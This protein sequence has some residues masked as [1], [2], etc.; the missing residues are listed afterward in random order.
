MTSTTNARTAVPVAFAA[1]VGL[2]LA[3]GSSAY[4]DVTARSKRSYPVSATAA[5]PPASALAVIRSVSVGDGPWGVAVDQDDDTVY[6]SNQGEN[7]ISVIDGRSGSL[8]GTVG[9]GQAP[10]GVSVDQDDD[11]V[12]VANSG[13]GNISVVDGRSL[14]L[15]DDTVAVGANPLGIDVDQ[16]DDTIYVS[17]NGSTTVSIIDA[18]SGTR[19]T[20]SLGDQ[21][22]GVV[23]DQ[24]DD[25]L[26][27]TDFNDDRVSI[28]AG[29][30]KLVARTVGVGTSPLGIAVDQDDDTVYVTNY[31]SG[32]VSVLDG[33]SSQLTDDTMDVGTGPKGIAVDQSD[34]TVYVANWGSDNLSV[35]DGSGPS[36]TDDT[37]AVG[38]DPTGVA[39]DDDSDLVYV[40]NEGS[41]SVSVIARV[42]PTLSVSSGSP[43]DTI[44]VLLSAS[45]AY[46]FD[47]STVQSIYFDDTVAPGL[48]RNPGENSW[49]VRVPSGSGSGTIRVE[50]NGGR[51][52]SAGTFTIAQPA[53]TPLLGSPQS[54]SSG[55]NVDVTN[56]DPQWGWAVSSSVGSATAGSPTGSTLP[57]SVTGLAAGQ[58]A[59]L[60]VVTSRT[61][62]FNGTGS[63]GGSAAPAPVPPTPSPR[64]PP[65]PPLGVSA[66]PGDSSAVVTW[67]T[68]E[69]SGTFPITEYVVTSSP[70]SHSCRAEAP[71]VTCVVTE[72]ENGTPYTFRVQAA[73]AA[74]WSAESSPSDEVTPAA[75][76]RA[77]LQITGTR[78]EVRGR[79]GILVDGVSDHVSPGTHLRPW[80]RFPG[81]L[82]YRQGAA[83]ILVQESGEFSWQRRTGKR[84]YVYVKS[85]DGTVKSNRVIVR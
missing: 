28:V 2:I 59:T 60:T 57:V 20:L 32:T 31:F 68:P 69:S 49:S 65:T 37:V 71:A 12:Y 30:P 15:T 79:P 13:A 61:G 78:G 25:T 9:V 3:G 41:D 50:L 80:I 27:V 75:S 10:V 55:F 8:V 17:D 76:P 34:D 48:T 58:S 23:L 64:Y 43:D 29:E 24:S 83:E 26:Y 45:V 63:T 4:G 35:I 53:R 77:I 16:T 51:S 85:D 62:Y 7:S 21:P 81:Q 38:V 19:T 39:V 47:D 5:A 84:T 70:G 82:S 72:L 66:E 18:K 42:T 33:R 54:T 67:R 44:T 22:F 6:V 56:Y 52:A 36:L 73:N 11:T 46:P 14:A 1:V 40:T 74:G